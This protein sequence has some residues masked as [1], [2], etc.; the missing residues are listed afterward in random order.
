MLSPVKLKNILFL[1]KRANKAFHRRSTEMLAWRRVRNKLGSYINGIDPNSI[2][3]FMPEDEKPA[4][5][6][7]NLIKDEEAKYAVSILSALG[8]PFHW[9][10]KK[11]RKAK[12]LISK[13]GLFRTTEKLNILYTKDPKKWPIK[14]WTPAYN[15]RKWAGSDYYKFA[16]RNN[17]F[18]T[19]LV[20][21]PNSFAAL[22]K[23]KKY[24]KRIGN[25]LKDIMS[26]GLEGVMKSYTN[27]YTV[28]TGL[29]LRKD[30]I[31]YTY[32][33]YPGTV[34]Y[35]VN[36]IRRPF[37]KP[38]GMNREYLPNIGTVLAS[39]YMLK[40]EQDYRYITI[41]EGLK[42]STTY[43]LDAVYDLIDPF[44]ERSYTI[45]VDTKI[46]IAFRRAYKVN[47]PFNLIE[48]TRF[49]DWFHFR[50]CDYRINNAA[51]HI[52]FDLFGD[53][54]GL[55]FKSLYKPKLDSVFRD[56]ENV[57]RV[58]LGG[59]ELSKPRYFKKRIVNMIGP[60]RWQKKFKHF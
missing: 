1:Y 47:E 19:S 10:K 11:R 14:R 5:K 7:P 13:S 15:V 18:Q 51:T 40:E 42:M 59:L 39:N 35:R 2:E 16:M 38:Y 52:A 53:T 3:L 57:L 49:H 32:S 17:T 26:E 50:Y 56:N 27:A 37:F 48:N 41:D 29:A 36:Y 31:K 60:R 54:A 58:S 4:L 33:Q 9:R 23:T 8:I 28:R 24:L 12:Q 55:Y 43:N 45:D 20:P 21:K 22:Q 6:I 30:L 46:Q 25:T 44:Y 34:Q